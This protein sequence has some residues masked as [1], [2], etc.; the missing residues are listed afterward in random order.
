MIDRLLPLVAAHILIASAALALGL[1]LALPLGVYAA[2]HR[3]VAQGVLGFASLIQTILRWRC[4]RFSIRCCWR[5][6]R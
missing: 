1:V 2:R 3:R 6:A 5:S 4:W